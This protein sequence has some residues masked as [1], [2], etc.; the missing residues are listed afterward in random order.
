MVCVRWYCKYG[1]TY[2]DLAERMQENARFRITPA[3]EEWMSYLVICMGP[4]DDRLTNQIGGAGMIHFAS[5][6]A[7]NLHRQ[8]LDI[9][10]EARARQKL[11]KPLCVWFTGLSASGKST[12]ANLIEKRL[13]AAGK[14][15][16]VLDGDNIRQGLNRDLGFSKADR[17]ENIR[18]IAEVARLLVDAGLIVLVSFIS[19]YRADR[20]FARSCFE[21]GEFI[22]VFV[23]TPFE[24]CERRDPKGLYAKA[25]RGELA[26]FTGIDS[27]YEPPELP[28]IRLDTVRCSAE[29]CVESILSTLGQ[30]WWGRD[31]L[32]PR[33]PGP[34]L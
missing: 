17:I 7:E 4:R 34:E 13:F 29:E 26:N 33:P 12:I 3:L 20:E 16:Y 10:K 8:V 15:T 27:D 21:P 25:R 11:Q 6:E 22:E 14:H 30:G 18:R 23:D 9:D 1:I 32:N 5:L 31:D 2:R 28:E 24:E 19:P